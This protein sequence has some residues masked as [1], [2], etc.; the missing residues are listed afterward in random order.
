V[1]CDDG[2]KVNSLRPASS[3]VTGAASRYSTYSCGNPSE[4]PGDDAARKEIFGMADLYVSTSGSDSNDGSQNAPFRTIA[5]ASQ[6]AQP[7]TTVHVA[8]GTYDGGFTTSASGTASA[9]ITYE[10]DGARIVDGGSAP[11]GMAWWNKG[12]YVD[13]KG[14][15]IDG[16]GGSSWRI[17]LYNSGSHSTFQNNQVHDILSNSSAF[18]AASASGNGGAGIEMDNYYGATDGSVIGNV[19]YNIGPS[20]VKSSLVHGIYQTEPGTVSNNLVYNVVGAGITTWHGAHN[21]D[22]TNNTVDDARSCGIYVGSGDSGAT[23]STGDYLNVSRNIVTNSG[24]GITE[25]GT[26]GIH[27]TYSGNVIYNDGSSPI[28]L[29][30]GLTASG[31]ISA[32]PEYVNAAAHDYQLQA[33]SPAAG[34]GYNPGSSG[35]GSD[36]TPTPAPTPTPVP[37]P[38]DSITPT[39]SDTTPATTTDTTPTTTTTDTNPAGT[40]TSTPSDT[41]TLTDTNATIDQSNVTISGSG[42]H[43]L[44]INGSSDKV[45]LSGGQ[46]RI[47]DSGS[48]N[49]IAFPGI[50]DG[51]HAIYGDVFNNGDTFDLHSLMSSTDWNGAASDIGSYLKM[52]TNWT[53]ENAVLY[54]RPTPTGSFQQVATFNGSGAVPLSDFLQ[55]A[56]S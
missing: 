55:H 27:N 56:V 16:S 18:S 35:G 13:V 38:S 15:E 5:A 47:H 28:D 44:F 14:F 50:G 31:T 26:T 9:P 17:G 12:D 1:G 46:E 43:L 49:T 34:A 48:D 41:I 39:A 4:Q 10:S 52:G 29:Q 2:L 7:G 6:A 22:I 11:D 42:N 37:A 36:T 25:G 45:E 30:N 40:T 20:G 19:V 24:D 3:A 33:G 21:I 32:D 53:G 54:A 51:H 8:A 23:S